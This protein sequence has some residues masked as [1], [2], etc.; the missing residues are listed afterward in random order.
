MLVVGVRVYGSHVRPKTCCSRLCRPRWSAC[1][2]S[3]V[4]EHELQKAKNMVEAA[5]V[6]SQETVEGQARK[7]G[8]GEMMGDH[9]L[10]GT[11]RAQA[12]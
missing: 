9:T 10:A 7:L 2:E 6:F 8:Y 4:D 3:P 1:A 11:L 5:Y 12:V